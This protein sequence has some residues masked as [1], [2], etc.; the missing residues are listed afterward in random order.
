[1]FSSSQMLIY[2][3]DPAASTAF[4]RSFSIAS[5]SRPRRTSQL[6]TS[7]ALPW[8]CGRATRSSRP[9]TGPAA[10]AELVLIVDQAG[11]VDRLWAD[12]QGR[13][14]AVIQPP[15]DL[16]FGRTFAALDPDG[17]RLRVCAPTA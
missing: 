10:S 5:R 16:Y 9:R 7:T 4:Y 3:A 13:G 15:T 2:V 12:W 17:H 14:V 11:A 1:M 8:L 6:S